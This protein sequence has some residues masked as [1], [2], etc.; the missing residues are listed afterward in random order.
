[1]PRKI[2]KALSKDWENMVSAIPNDLEASAKAQGALK[3]H[4][5]FRA[6]S[7]LLRVILMDAPPLSLRNTALGA[8]CLGVC[9]IS[10]QALEERLL[11]SRA[12]LRQEQTISQIPVVAAD[13]PQRRPLRL[14]VGRLPANQAENTREHVRRQACLPRMRR[15]QAQASPQR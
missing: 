6:A 9:S 12:W 10:R 8:A 2:T 5:G 14:M 15:R 13:D 11:G 3:R 4:R 7:D 1:M